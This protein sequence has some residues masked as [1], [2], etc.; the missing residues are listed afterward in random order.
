[1][2]VCSV[3]RSSWSCPCALSCP[4]VARCAYPASRPPRRQGQPPPEPKERTANPLAGGRI[5]LPSASRRP[6]QDAP[7]KPRQPVPVV[8][9]T[10]GPVSEPLPPAFVPTVRRGWAGASAAQIEKALPPQAAA[11]WRRY[12]AARTAWFGEPAGRTLSAAA[13]A[14]LQELLPV[15]EACLGPQAARQLEA[16]VRAWEGGNGQ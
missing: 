14:A 2:C 5:L 15:I 1:M 4:C 10:V 6:R 7:A 12:L 8:R 16:A 11:A 13:E 9:P 3:C